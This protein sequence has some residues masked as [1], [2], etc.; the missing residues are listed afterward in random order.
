MGSGGYVKIEWL[1]VAT[2]I[3]VTGLAASPLA[4]RATT[5]PSVP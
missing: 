3:A 2:T 1:W 4:E 5:D